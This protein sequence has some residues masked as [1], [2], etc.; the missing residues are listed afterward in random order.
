[1]DFDSIVVASLAGLVASTHFRQRPLWD[2]SNWAKE[3]DVLD[4]LPCFMMND[5]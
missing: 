1:M 3:L 4:R 2:R 5:T